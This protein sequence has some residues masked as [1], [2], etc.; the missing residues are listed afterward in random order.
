[1]GIFDEYEKVMFKYIKNELNLN[2]TQLTLYFNQEQPYY[3]DFVIGDWFYNFF[4]DSIN[5]DN[6]NKFGANID[7]PYDGISKDEYF[8]LA[9]TN[10]LSE[11][12]TKEMVLKLRTKVKELVDSCTKEVKELLNENP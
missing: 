11:A 8:N 10:D 7:F 4:S 5:V 12:I 3:F 9:M 1:M 2:I 6:F